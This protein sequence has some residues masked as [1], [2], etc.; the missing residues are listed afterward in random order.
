MLA[1]GRADDNEETIRTRL[2]VYRD[3]TEPLIEHYDD[4]I[5][6]IVAEGTVEEINA[7]TLAALAK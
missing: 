6:N 3:E 7:R 1:R 5:I 4:K 2:E